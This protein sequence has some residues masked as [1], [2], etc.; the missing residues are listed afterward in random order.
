[1]Q[2]DPLKQFITFFFGVSDED[3]EKLNK[4]LNEL[5]ESDE[6]LK[7]LFNQLDI[8]LALSIWIQQLTHE[9]YKRICDRLEHLKEYE[10]LRIFEKVVNLQ[11]A[12]F[13]QIEEEE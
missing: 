6:E 3:V 8:L 11:H 12:V 10:L 13:Q 7:F 4:R 2:A 9:V 5:I 1:M